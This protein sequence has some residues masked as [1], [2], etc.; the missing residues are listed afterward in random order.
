VKASLFGRAISALVIVGAVPVGL[1]AG[2]AVLSATPAF[3]APGQECTGTGSP[4]FVLTDLAGTPQS[5]KVG[6]AFSTPL[7]VQVTESVGS[8]SCPASNVSVTFTV[9]NTGAGASFNGGSNVVSVEADSSGTATAPTL[10][11]DNVTGSFTVVASFDDYVSAPF[12]L[13][14]TTVGVVT[15]VTVTSG[16]SQSAQIGGAFADPLEVTVTDGYGD[17]VAG[18]TVDF[19][20]VTTA[21]AG[22][23]FSG[24]GASASVQTDESGLATSPNLTA[25]TTAGPFTVTASVQGVNSVATFN[26]TVQAGVA[27]NLTA[28]VGASQSTELGTDF[29]VPLAVTVT[30]TDG[31]PLVGA[32]V[33]FSAPRTGASGVFAGAGATAA[34]VTG[35]DGVATA[36]DFSANN[37][38]GGYVVMASV[39]GLTSPATFALVNEPRTTASAPGVD[40]SYWL[41]TSTGKVLRSGAVPGLGPMSTK[42][43]EPVVGMAATPGGE[44][45]WLVTSTGVVRAYGDAVNYGS[46]SKSKLHLSK[47][48]VGIGATPDGKGYWL[49][50]SG[51]AIFNYGDAAAYGSPSLSKL[52]LTKP[53]VGIAATPDG[54]GYWLVASD[55]GI[56]NYGDA[57]FYGS[58]SGR[59]LSKAIVGIAAASRGKG[60]WLVAANGSVYPFGPSATNY[61]SST[62]L[63][64]QPVK[65]IVATPDGAGYWVVSANGTAAGFGNAGAQG[66]ATSAKYTVVGGAA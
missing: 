44:G 28:G 9:Y 42:S 35:P 31:N 58:T 48:I 23:T 22:A 34:V 11:A 26:L 29:P 49:V 12:E 46:P 19:T 17:P 2:A 60:Y 57:A 24:A 38:T 16:N 47:P 61:G 8:S 15:S 45:Y 7:E 13:T 52:H 53:I 14:N 40:G 6:Q 18:A 5:A 37:H 43:T 25:G 56:F 10:Y 64:P 51:G 4:S 55:G 20:A 33:T 36:P 65:A 41:V 50:A 39:A 1:S 63:S 3:A 54:K 30:D 32:T 62:A 27:S 59:H 21:G 66:S